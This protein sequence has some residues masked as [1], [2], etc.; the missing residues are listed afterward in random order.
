MMIPKYDG[1]S[2]L[3]LSA[4]DLPRR[5][6]VLLCISLCIYHVPAQVRRPRLERIKLA[7]VTP[8]LIA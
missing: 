4:G 1:M 6:Q 3:F 2:C 8:W 7:G 5:V